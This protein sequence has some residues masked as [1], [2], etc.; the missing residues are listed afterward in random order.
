MPC[1]KYGSKFAQCLSKRSQGDPR[2]CRPCNI[3]S[4]QVVSPL[5]IHSN[6]WRFVEGG[7]KLKYCTVT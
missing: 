7:G 5:F 1:Q 6:M 2:C 4:T 3:E